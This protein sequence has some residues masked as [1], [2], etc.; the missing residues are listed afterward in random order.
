MRQVRKLAS[1]AGIGYKQWPEHTIFY[2]NVEVNLDN[3]FY[4]M[5]Q[6]ALDWEERH[7]KDKGHGWLLLHPIKKLQLYKEYHQHMA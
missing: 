7:G 6:E 1:G 5:Y 4:E 3:D 2:K